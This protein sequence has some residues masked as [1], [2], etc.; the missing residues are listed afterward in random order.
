MEWSEIRV[1]TEE[2]CA[3]AIAGL[4]HEWGAGGVI[5]E[6]P[7]AI[8]SHI[9]Q[10]LWD[11]HAF[12]QE[13]LVRNQVIIRA[14]YPAPY[15]PTPAQINDLKATAGVTCHIEV[16]TVN[17]EDWADNWKAYYHVTP[18]GRRL[19]IK[20]TWEEYL[21]QADE[22]VIELDPGMA[23]G[24]GT[25]VTTRQCLEL[26]ES[27]VEAGQ[28]VLDIGTGSGILA[29]AA[30]KLGAAKVRAI[31]N[32]PVAV[33]T[34][35]ENVEQNQVSSVIRVE[36]KD[37][38]EMDGPQFD[39]VIANLTAQV[40]GRLLGRLIRLTRAG[41]RVIAAGIGRE[42]WPGLKEVITNSGLVLEQISEDEDW[43]AVLARRV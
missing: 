32:D 7:Q 5:I 27:V 33:K 31:D 12:D 43:V 17:D 30:A 4:F 37:L 35:R 2:P 21:P 24:T 1:S 10:G 25:H 15:S 39:L 22:L 9:A 38:A 16:L 26:M 8:R 34:A 19:V 29:I 42:Q 11:D 40:L 28:N 41:G 23:F 6:D 3:E 20:P 13:Y 14:F 36:L 18:L